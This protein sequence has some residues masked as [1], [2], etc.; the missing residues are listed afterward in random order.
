MNGT[1]VWNFKALIVSVLGSALICGLTLVYIL[2]IA[3]SDTYFWDSFLWIFS[4]VVAAPVVLWC[5]KTYSGVVYGALVWF[6]LFFVVFSYVTLG[7]DGFATGLLYG[8]SLV[9]S[10]IGAFIAMFIAIKFKK[11]PFLIG[12]SLPFLAVLL[13]VCVTFVFY[14]VFPN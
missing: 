1:T 4:T 12:F 3:V 8:L 2:N 7:Y 14:L 13:S 11:M 10:Y 9:P 6:S 5:C